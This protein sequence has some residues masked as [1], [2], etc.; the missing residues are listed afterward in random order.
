MGHLYALRGAF[1][2]Q[3]RDTATPYQVLLVSLGQVPTAVAAAWIAR[4]S[5]EH[6]VSLAI[7]V[8]ATFV[9]I[10]NVAV[11]QTGWSLL[12]ERWAGTLELNLL[13]RSP[14]ALVMLGKSLAFVAF[15]GLIGLL[16]FTAALL[17]AT[18]IAGIERPASFALSLT[19]VVLAVVSLQFI[20]A[21]LGFLVGAQGGFFNAIRPLGVVLSGFFYPVALLPDW[22]EW[23]AR[24][25]PTAW[26]MEALVW[27]INGKED[28]GRIA[29]NW[30]PAVALVVLVAIV[31]VVLFVQAE[32]RARVFGG[33]TEG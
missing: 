23:L 14:L 15:F 4:S 13:S 28:I 32:R 8:G 5:V 16:S 17:V 7:A 20:F 27:S 26:A 1:L 19:L 33:L 30:A 22:L 6:G 24:L 25:L 12:G 2:Q 11:F 29:L 10:W 3:W 21:P 9:V 31:E 18:E